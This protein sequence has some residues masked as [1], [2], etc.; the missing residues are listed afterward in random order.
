[1]K[2]ATRILIA[3]LALS[4]TAAS[5]RTI[6][7]AGTDSRLDGVICADPELRD[8]QSRIATAY[9]NATTIWNGAIA[10]YVQREQQEWLI[11]FRT[12][13]TMETA[14]D[15]DCL[16]TDRGCIGEQLRERVEDMESGAY[17][18]S[19]VYRAANGMK[20][21]LHPGP[22]KGYSVRVYDPA[23]LPKVDLATLLA[24]QAAKWEGPQ[25]MVST[26]GN[27]NGQPL[28]DADGCTLRLTPR[29]LSIEVTQ[30]GACQGNHFEGSYSRLLG[31]TLRGYALELH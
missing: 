25:L 3:L 27:A 24:M 15:E 31:E 30:T 10:S 21:L 1:M 5:A 16:I 23:R 4:T 11:S 7:C 28:P 22:A 14:I 8:Y 12:I 9:S 2:R 17:V 6:D 19:G 13:E 29:P 26:M 20:L 18:H